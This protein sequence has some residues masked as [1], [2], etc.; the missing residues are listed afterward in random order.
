MECERKGVYHRSVSPNPDAEHW[1]I[2]FDDLSQN[3]DPSQ[4]PTLANITYQSLSKSDVD[5]Y[6][7]A[8]SLSTP[9]LLDA[10]AANGLW[11][12]FVSG[13]SDLKKLTVSVYDKVE[14][15]IRI[16][17]VGFG[18][19]RLCAD[20]SQAYWSSSWRNDQWGFDEVPRD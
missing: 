3:S 2:R 11:D 14:K 7:G 5:Q 19:D 6:L 8:L 1:S 10:S 17:G 15:S 9:L 18:S 16:V 13:V 4:P 20:S 12:T